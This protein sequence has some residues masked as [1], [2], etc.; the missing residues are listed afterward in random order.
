MKTYTHDL[1]PRAPRSSQQL[2]ARG[3]KR[4]KVVATLGPGCDDD[5]ILRAMYHAGMNIARFNM[6]HGDHETHSLRLEQIR[7]LN[8][9]LDRPVGVLVDLQ[10]PK[11]RL[12]RFKGGSAPWPEGHRTIITTEDMGEGDAERIGCTYKELHQDVR[13]GST[14]LIDDGRLRLQ[15]ISVD[16]RDVHCEVLVGGEA[17]SSKG[18]NLP[19]VEVSAPSLTDK[20]K[21][22][23]TW[24]L[25]NEADYVA[26]SFVRSA[27]DIRNLRRR[28]AESGR[29]LPIIAKIE[30][31][32][33]VQDMDEIIIAADGIMVARGDL[34]IEISSERL[35]AV[36]KHLIARANAHGKL[37]ITATQ[38]LES[39]ITSPIPTRAET[40]DVANAIFDGTD[41]VMLSAE[42]AAGKYPAEAVEEMMRISVAA[43]DS[44]YLTITEL[45]PA[46]VSSQRMSHALASAAAHLADNI[47]ARAVMV[48][49]HGSE[50]S[51][52]LSK[53]RATKARTICMCYD[54]ATWRRVSL[55]YGTIPLRIDYH[56][57]PSD[58]LEKGIAEALRQKVV[59]Q[60]EMVVALMGFASDTASAIKVVRV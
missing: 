1:N 27:Q 15:V 39:M 11:I 41:A 52:L 60:G 48:F 13:A 57:D 54:D 9:E 51:L 50:K 59:S 21:A 22:D 35:P 16:G 4:T 34:G 32:E 53:L 2:T 19:G 56:D 28:I 12:T 31:P 36:Q 17:K 25:S 10:G 42:T 20:D 49:S 26:L 30:R 8:H 23:L 6:S 33:A 18:V 5:N 58:L 37:V 45:D 44:P 40:S 14:I 43:E 24:A 29:S 55:F 46:L 3:R 47:N 7:R 38:M